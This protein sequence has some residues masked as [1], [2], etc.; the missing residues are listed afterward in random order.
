MRP[1]IHHVISISLV[2]SHIQARAD[3]AKHIHTVSV[4]GT[5][6]RV[7]RARAEY[8]DQL[9]YSGSGE[10]DDHECVRPRDFIVPQQASVWEKIG[11]G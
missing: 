3:E 1:S 9:D 6:T 11:S 5:R 7:A 10:T 4:T 8:P 2:L